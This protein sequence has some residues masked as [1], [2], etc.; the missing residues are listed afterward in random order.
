M[1]RE[2]EPPRPRSQRSTKLDVP[3]YRPTEYKHAHDSRGEIKEDDFFKGVVDIDQEL[4]SSLSEADIT[5]DELLRN[6]EK[7]IPLSKLEVKKGIEYI[8]DREKRGMYSSLDDFKKDDEFPLESSVIESDKNHAKDLKE[9]FDKNDENNFREEMFEGLMV[10]DLQMQNWFGNNVEVF[11]TTKYDDYTNGVDLVMEW[12]NESEEPVRLAVDVTVG[13]T[14]E[15][16]LKKL[17]SN[18]S[19]SAI[20]EQL[21]DPETRGGEPYYMSQ[22]KYYEVFDGLEENK[23][24]LNQI[25]RVVLALDKKGVRFLMEDLY[26]KNDE[27]EFSFN[28]A[29]AEVHPAQIVLLEEAR[30]Q[31]R[32]QL[33]VSLSN[34]FTEIIS[35]A[36]TP[37]QI[38]AFTEV[39]LDMGRDKLDSLAKEVLKLLESLSLDLNP[40]ERNQV[41]MIKQIAEN[42]D[43]LN[44]IL[45][46]KKTHLDIS[47]DEVGKWRTE[48]RNA[49]ALIER[50]HIE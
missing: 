40:K 23:K 4:S 42:I 17:D 29:K 28:R 45:E 43:N 13:M 12:E 21:E 19:N 11:P 22:V 16:L 36:L 35:G 9:E 7:V 33:I 5:R 48:D 32:E 24:S 34:D 47:D 18:D 46:N 2:T 31:L 20:L 26:D 8:S 25:P 14:K 6:E 27:D 37:E 38:D 1:S 49:H 3:K 41:K 10:E 50:Y 44:K 39:D 15:T 30:N